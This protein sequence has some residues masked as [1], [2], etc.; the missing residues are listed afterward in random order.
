MA[1]W[2]ANGLQAARAAAKWVYSMQRRRLWVLKRTTVDCPKMTE[3]TMAVVK[4]GSLMLLL[5]TTAAK[6][7]TTEVQTA[8]AAASRVSYLLL[9]LLLVRLAR[10]PAPGEM[11]VLTAAVA[12]MVGGNVMSTV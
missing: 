4:S 2:G 8:R 3:T 10:A 5:T 12:P 9:L 1:N 11:Y 7:R 6:V